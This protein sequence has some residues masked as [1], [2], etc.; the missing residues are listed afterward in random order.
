M[1]TWLSN[2]KRE[3]SSALSP[4]L[5][6]TPLVGQP[7]LLVNSAKTAFKFCRGAITQSGTMMA[8][9]PTTWRMSII[10]STKGSLL[11]R[12]VLKKT[13][14]IPTPITINVPRQV[15][16]SYVEAFNMIR[17]CRLVPIRKALPM[18]TDC[19]PRTQNHLRI[20]LE[21]RLRTVW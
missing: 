20:I 3:I 17:P 12:K 8:N 21:K 10:H 7:P 1:C 16:G 4:T 13:V 19:H 15:F 11:A 9:N 2:H 5:K 6:D 14:E 18:R